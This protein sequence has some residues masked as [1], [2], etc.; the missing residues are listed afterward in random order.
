MFYQL[1]GPPNATVAADARLLAAD[2]RDR[3]G[4]AR[5]RDD[6]PD[7]RARQPGI[8][9]MLFKPWEERTQERARAAAGAAGRSGAR[10]PAAGSFAFQL[11]PLPGAQGVPVQFVIT[12]T[13]PFE[14]LNEVAQAVL[15]KAKDERQV[16]LRRHRPQDRQAAGDACVVDRDKVATLGLTQQDVGSA[17]GAALGGGYVNYFSIAGPL[18]QGDSAGAAGRSPESRSGARLLHA[19]AGRLA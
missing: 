7:H 5:V 3:Q 10:S 16:L 12:T 19:R 4:A 15:Q 2:V 17:L 6:V 1:K 18:V 14:N 9:G 13:E 8:G 11:P